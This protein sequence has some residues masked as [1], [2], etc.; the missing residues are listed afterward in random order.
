MWCFFTVNP[1]TKRNN[2]T[3]AFLPYKH[4]PTYRMH[5]C[6]CVANIYTTKTYTQNIQYIYRNT[7][8]NLPCPIIMRCS[9]YYNKNHPK[10]KWVYW[11]H[12]I[13]I[14]H[15]VLLAAIPSP[16]TPYCAVPLHY[17]FTIFHITPVWMNSLTEYIITYTHNTYPYCTTTITTTT[18][19]FFIFLLFPNHL[20]QWE[21]QNGRKY[22]KEMIELG[23]YPP[24]TNN[25]R[26]II[27]FCVCRVAHWYETRKKIY[28]WWWECLVSTAASA[29][30]FA[31]I[32][33]YWWGSGSGGG[34]NSLRCI[35][36]RVFFLFVIV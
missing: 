15:T 32:Y 29:I 7:N 13:F 21:A 31:T 19:T 2:K 17:T 34:C 16:L 9:D 22:R 20:T 3:Y 25:K 4:L 28:W 26:I 1:S 33:Y 27:F 18:Q 24:N 12:Q 14:I 23:K 8:N 30:A 11:P 6:V 5:V 35:Y 36:K 10:M